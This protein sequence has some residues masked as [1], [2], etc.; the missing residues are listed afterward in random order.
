V[1]DKTR[2]TV[3]LSGHCEA[4]PEHFLLA[5]LRTGDNSALASLRAAEVDFEGLRKDLVAV[6]ATPVAGAR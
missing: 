3:S 4:E 6:L 2:D 5:L 1:L